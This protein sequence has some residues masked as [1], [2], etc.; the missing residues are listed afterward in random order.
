MAVILA[1]DVGATKTLLFVFDGE[2]TYK[3]RYVTGDFAS[4]ADLVQSF[5]SACGVRPELAC[6][7]VAGPV[8]G[9]S[10]YLTNVGWQVSALDLECE[11]GIPQVS[12]INDFVAI[13]YGI[14]NLSP[15]DLL[16][17]QTGQPI[18]QAPIAVL[19]A[20]TG[21]GQAYLTWGKQGYQVHPSEGGHTDFA[22]RNAAELAVWQVLCQKYGRVSVEHI[23][24][25]QGIA[26]IYQALGG[27]AR[28]PSQIA[29]TAGVGTDSIAVKTMEFFASAY[30]AE[31]G[32]L[33]LKLLP[34]G[35][36]YVAGGI[37]PKILPWL[38][39]GD[40]FLQAMLA[41]GKAGRLLQDIPTY[42]VLNQEVGL[43]GALRCAQQLSHAV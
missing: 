12:L 28:Q 18:P 15:Q 3:E 5:L 6:F 36:L 26:H 43:L 38:T 35:G 21:M 11:L 40:R 16:C 23:I 9:N 30:G 19:G 2:Q 34:Y 14:L 31:A 10:A 41:K 17:L 33:A 4:L 1:G 39:T 13:A 22:P 37:A 20:G 27:E 7:G 8:V 42:I 29:E 32:N 25:G 24:S